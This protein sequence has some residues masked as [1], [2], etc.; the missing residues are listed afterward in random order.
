MK[1]NMNI[2]EKKKYRTRLKHFKKDLSKYILTSRFN[3]STYMENHNYRQHHNIG[4]IYCSPSRV[5]D[6]YL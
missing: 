2:T 4:C 1:E 3:N 6:E 5:S